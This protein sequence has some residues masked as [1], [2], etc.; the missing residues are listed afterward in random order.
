MGDYNSPRQCSTGPREVICLSL[1]FPPLLLLIGSVIQ[2]VSIDN[3]STSHGPVEHCLGELQS[4]IT[5]KSLC[6]WGKHGM[7]INA[8]AQNDPA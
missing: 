5:L 1:M 4:P 2:V 6:D 3:Q 8:I 7:T